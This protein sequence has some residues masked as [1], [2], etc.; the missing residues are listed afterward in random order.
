MLGAAALESTAITAIGLALGALAAA[1]TL[2]AMAGTAASVAGS[3][4][5]GV[6]WSLAAAPGVA[7]LAVT[8]LTSVSAT[9]FATRYRPIT[10]LAARE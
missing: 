2:V 9:W 6:P 4:T 7:C 3:P 10:L 1:G 5:V 8:G